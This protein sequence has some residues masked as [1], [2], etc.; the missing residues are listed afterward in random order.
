M[1][2]GSGGITAK[3]NIKDTLTQRLDLEHSAV[4]FLQTLGY[5]DGD[6]QLLLN[7]GQ[8]IW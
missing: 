1:V 7:G 5:F 2:I 3:T 6:F 8:K 4:F